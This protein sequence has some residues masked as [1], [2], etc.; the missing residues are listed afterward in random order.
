[1]NPIVSPTNIAQLPPTSFNP[2]TNSGK[3]SNDIT[4]IITIY[5]IIGALI[6]FVIIGGI[7][8]IF[9][10]RYAMKF[11]KLNNENGE[12]TIQISKR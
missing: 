3:N 7:F 5:I 11:Q 12:T 9:R 8:F 1:M 10:R 4:S 2:T 6:P